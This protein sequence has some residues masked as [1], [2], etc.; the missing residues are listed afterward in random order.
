MFT[1]SVTLNH[2]SVVIFLIL[3]LLMIYQMTIQTKN[4]L[5]R[6]VEPSNKFSHASEMTSSVF[7]Q[8]N[9]ETKRK[10]QVD[11]IVAIVAFK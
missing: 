9:L 5:V 10:S 7:E 2:Y 11:L 4:K 1:E 3:N 6:D 8:I